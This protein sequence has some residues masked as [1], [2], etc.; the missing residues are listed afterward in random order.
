MRK[1]IILLLMPVIAFQSCMLHDD[2]RRI[3]GNEHVITNNAPV[4]DFTGV[5]AGGS[6]DVYVTEGSPTAV[7]IEGEDNIISHVKM[8][9]RNGVLTIDS[10][11]G[12]SLNPHRDV[13]VFITAPRF[14][15]LSTSGSGNITG[16]TKI[17]SD[18]KL[19]LGSSGSGSLKLEVDAPEITVGIS[20]AGFV[21]LAGET[22]KFNASV[23]GAGSIK[24][25]D[26]KSENV[27]CNISGTGNMEVYSSVKL[28]AGISGM[29]KIRY[30]GNPEVTKNVSG[31][32]NIQKVD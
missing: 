30:K 13:K 23:S 12:V 18:G 1:T 10:E 7:K 11:D 9:V 5:H 3:S 28:N 21:D 22:K 29:G 15:K 31:I 8:E 16:Q 14:S 6:F 25:F 4:G 20:G 2:R 24:A 17:T 27:E 32:G 19:E 26:L